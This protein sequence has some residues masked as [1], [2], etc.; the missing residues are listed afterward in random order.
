MGVR[1]IVALTIVAET[2]LSGAEPALSDPLS[3][4]NPL[5]DAEL[6]SREKFFGKLAQHSVG[7]LPHSGSLTVKVSRQQ[8]L[9]VL[10]QSLI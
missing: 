9:R 1:R 7:W 3:D 5:L 4:A 10:S 2:A 8:F 6:T